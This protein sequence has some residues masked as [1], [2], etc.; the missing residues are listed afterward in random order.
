MVFLEKYVSYNKHSLF[1]EFHP[2]K[3]LLHDILSSIYP[4]LQHT[5]V[6]RPPPIKDHS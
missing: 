6:E 3:Y 1:V 5:P 4:Y 2:E